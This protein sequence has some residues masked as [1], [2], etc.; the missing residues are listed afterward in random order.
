MKQVTSKRVAEIC[1][2]HVRFE[3]KIIIDICYK[4]EVIFLDIFTSL[5]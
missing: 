3:I 4:F 1:L 2:M 5:I